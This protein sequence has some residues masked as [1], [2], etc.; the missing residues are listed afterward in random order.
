MK[1]ISPDGKWLAFY[2]GFAGNNWFDPEIG[3]GPFNLTLKLLDLTTGDVQIITPLL[4]KDYPDNFTKAEKQINDPTITNIMLRSAFLSG[5]TQSIAWSPDGEHLAFAG[6]M[7]GLSSDLYVYDVTTK[8][9]RRL[10]SG[11]EELQWIEWSPDGEWIVHGSA[12]WAGE[13]M[14]FDV[15]VATVD[16]SSVVQVSTTSGSSG[17]RA[18]LNSQEYIE[19]DAANGPGQ[20]VLRLVNIR[21]GGITKLWDGSFDS[22][23]VDKSGRWIAVIAHS[24]DAFPAP[25]ANFVPAIYLININTLK[26]SRVEFPDSSHSY[27]FVNTFGSRGRDFVLLDSTSQ[28][29]IFLSSDGVLTSTDLGDIMLSVSP[30]FKYWLA[31]TN[32]DL[33]IFSVGNTP[34]KTISVS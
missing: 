15:Y 26:K 3:D 9:I 23:S 2:T 21:T 18:W 7:D 20:Y 17:I 19:N 8:A 10:S 22:Y 11:E 31:V 34:I 30:N 13:G 29:P 33:K 28:T 5:L 4:S 32:Q 6:Q 12:Y 24:I 16:G 27:H 14:S 1:F 25:D